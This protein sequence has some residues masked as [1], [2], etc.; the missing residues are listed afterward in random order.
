[1]LYLQTKYRLRNLFGVHVKM[2][3]R[4]RERSFFE[5]SIKRSKNNV[6]A[7]NPHKLTI[8]ERLLK[9]IED[10]EERINYL[11]SVIAKDMEDYDSVKHIYW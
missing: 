7:K 10:L 5:Q 9:K 4:K 8:M 11:E 6:T 3:K 1:M 2:P